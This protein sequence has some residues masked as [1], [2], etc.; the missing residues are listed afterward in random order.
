MYNPA[1]TEIARMMAIQAASK[2][3][4]YLPK[5]KA[6]P[7]D[8]SVITELQLACY[9]SLGLVGAIDRPLGLSH[10]LGYALGSPYSIPHGIT[11][12]LTLGH[13]VKL[14]AKDPS[15]AQQLSRVAP[16]IGIEVNQGAS[17]EELATAVGQKVLD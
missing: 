9:C 1:A 12:C 14:M 8:E 16:N 7:K 15:A 13:V 17:N 10:T 4:T 11:S 6:N 3:F 5:Y 2:L